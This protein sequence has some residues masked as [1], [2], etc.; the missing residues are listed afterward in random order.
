MEGYTHACETLRYVRLYE[1]EYHSLFREVVY[2]TGE[3]FAG[4]M[5]TFFEEKLVDRIRFNSGIAEM[6]AACCC[7]SAMATVGL[8]LNHQ[9]YGYSALIWAAERGLLTVVSALI[10]H[11]A[12]LELTDLGGKT[13]LVKAKDRKYASI[14][15]VLVKAGAKQ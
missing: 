13:A 12:N 5:G 10:Q 4:E 8:D 1:I 7:I 11:G 15:E 9:N 3:T 6:Q 2:P 14:V